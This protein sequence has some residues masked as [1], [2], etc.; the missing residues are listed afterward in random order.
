MFSS[1]IKAKR[2][3]TRVLVPVVL[4]MALLVATTMYV[5]NGRLQR[6][7]H[8]EAEQAL[9]TAEAVF[10]NSQKERTRTLMWR[11]QLIPKTPHFVAN[12]QQG[13]PNTI[14]A[15]LQNS[16]AEMPGDLIAYKDADG[17]TIA[18]AIRDSSLDAGEFETNSAPAVR[19]A[20]EGAP[21]VDTI[22][23]SDRLFDVVSFPVTLPSGQLL[24]ALTFCRK[25]GELEAQELS[26][27]SGCGIVLIA[28]TNVVASSLPRN[29]VLGQSVRLFNLVGTS[30]AT[31]S[32][33]HE[34]VATEEHYLPRI[35]AFDSMSNDPKIGYVL[36]YSY[37]PALHELKATQRII[38]SVSV[39]GIIFAT[40]IVWVLIRNTT[41]PLR[42]LRDSAEAV[43]RGDFTHRVHVKSQDECGELAQVFNRM[44][45]NLQASRS[46]LEQ[47]VRRLENTQA[48]LVQSEKLS[49]IGEF[50]AGVTHELNNPLAALLGFSD[51]LQ[52]TQVDERQKRFIDRVS[53]SARRCQK[54]V[55]SLLSFARQHAPE[56]KLTNVNEMVE[57]VIEIM[58]YEMRTSNIDVEKQLDSALPNVLAD[59]HQIQQVFLNI[60]NNARQA[61]EAHASSGAIR[62]RT[63]SLY[64]RVR[65][66][67]QDNGPGIPAE[68]LKKIF[69]PFF[70]TKEAGK[71][72]GLG[73][74]LSYGI[75]QEHGGTI[76]AESKLGMGTTFII[77]LPVHT[78]QTE[79]AREES[80]KTSLPACNGSGKRVLVIDDEEMI[81]DFLVEVLHAD[82]FDVDTAADGEAAL[83]R[84]RQKQYDLAL[85]DWKMP[86]LNG[87]KLFERVKTEDPSAAKRF[88]FMTG[89]IINEQ[90]EAFL[91]ENRRVCL[92]KPFSV[93][94]FRSAL[95][96]LA[97]AA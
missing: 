74:S 27:V 78:P 31:D 48:Q 83:K 91:K 39:I 90:A 97:E 26:A 5:V 41:R 63:E 14:Q 33:R 69:D 93:A 50:V 53:N 25:F 77:E 2:F 29:D 68:N 61:I 62:V 9:Q 12:F 16:K 64:E 4:V 28:N 56:R 15:M 71:G 49:A 40:A 70:T 95:A 32:D 65:I 43:G 19:Q 58:A 55:Q 86:G 89:D 79:P 34:I 17:K 88:V 23:L 44:T 47:T 46:E 7:L 36:L 10:R 87:Q 80:A 35:G 45:E 42:D 21:A 24:G 38:V 59:A 75:I 20:L 1:P 60:V 67:F 82:G 73:L 3:H 66:T 30:A 57:A 96:V 51:L 92:C 54:I 22:R 72:T 18:M 13:D 8:K 85:C 94:E 11:Y 6:Q 76:R 52:Q 37:A 81:L 84:L